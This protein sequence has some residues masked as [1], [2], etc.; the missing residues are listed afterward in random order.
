MR[1]TAMTMARRGFLATCVSSLALAATGGCASGFTRPAA[2]PGL[3]FDPAAFTEQ[4]VTISTET[5]DRQVVYRFWKA[6][7]YV[8]RPVDAAYQSLNISLP[9][10][11]DGRP[12]DAS[13]A[14]IL[15]ANAVGGYMPSSIASATGV[16]AGGMGGGM[17]PPQGAT[18]AMTEAPTGSA[19]MLSRGRMVSNA[20]L[21]LAAG[22]VVV[23]PGARGRTL[24]DAAG[25]FYG[26]APAAI[27]DLKAAVRYLKANRGRVPGNVDRIVSSGTS[28][29]GALSALLAA[30]G[31]S[32]LYQAELDAIG[33]ADA[34][35]AIWACG[36]WCPITDLEHA[37]IAYEWNWGRNALASGQSA[38]AAIS[39][40][41]AAGFA[42]YQSSLGLRGRDGFGPLTADRYGEYLLQTWLRPAAGRYLSRLSDADRQTYLAAHP[43][44]RWDGAQAGFGWD[45]FLDHVGARKKAAPAFDALD[46]STGENNLFGLETTRAR[47]FTDFA[48][49]RATGDASATLAADIPEKLHL[50]NPMGFIRDGNPGRARRWWI[51]VGAKD[52]DTS[53][54]VVGNLAT[55]LENAGDHVDTAIYWDAG[56]GANEDA[57]AF[58]RWIRE[59]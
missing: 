36:A 33:A 48:L 21:A 47:H 50:M 55:A 56:H 20:R 14:P 43:A 31:D 28:A 12:V 6:V 5:G 10:S 58:I 59:S 11:I 38:D 16:G 57:E 54:T 19:A 26:V 37:D 49:R 4:S 44:I 8:A 27:V 23:E 13:N 41:L 9:V 46:L 7:P 53:L 32:P 25:R 2:S 39:A 51:R 29:G 1:K 17:R 18:V 45:D 24:T 42:P 22:L 30:S 3:V 34:S 35:D 52:T 15:L 40:T